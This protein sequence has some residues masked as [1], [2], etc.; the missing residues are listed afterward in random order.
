MELSEKDLNNA[1]KK[2]NQVY[3][4]LKP[5]VVDVVAKLTKEVQ[6][7][8]DEIKSKTRDN[9]GAMSNTDIHSYML[10]L[11]IEAFYLEHDK[12]LSVLMQECAILLSKEAQAESFNCT[13]GTQGARN[14][15][16]MIESMPNQAVATVQTA[17]A[18]CMKGKLDEVHRL[19]SILQ[20]I[21]ISRNA[22]NKLRG[23]AEK[24]ENSNLRTDSISK[25]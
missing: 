6:S 25:D 21:L 1:K 22:E 4:D 8:I 7:I 23:A 3:K 5:I 17:V 20:N 9:I 24:D 19:I 12:D 15:Q 2:V 10:R 16:A 14:N 18:N 11:G 13:A